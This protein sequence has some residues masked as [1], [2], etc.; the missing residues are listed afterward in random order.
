MKRM[1]PGMV[2]PILAVCAL[3]FALCSV[4][5]NAAEVQGPQSGRWTLAASPYI[6]TGNVVVPAGEQLAIDPGVV[7]KV[8]GDFSIKVEGGLQAV[9]TAGNRIVFTSI[10]DRDFFGM[11]VPETGQPARDDWPGIIFT[12]KSLSAKNRLEYVII[13]YSRNPISA[14]AANPE[15]VNMTID[16][17]A[18]NVMM[19]NGRIVAIKPGQT[20][21]YTETKNTAPA[22]DVTK[23]QANAAQQNM[24]ENLPPEAAATL[25]GQVF[26]SETAEALPAVNIQLIPQ[27]RPNQRLGT[28]TG[29]A[30]E[31]VIG[32]LPP[33]EYEIRVSYISYR[34]QRQ[35]E[36]LQAGEIKNLEFALEYTGILFNPITVT[37][38]RR[39]EA[40]L[41]AP[42]AI[43]VLETEEILAREALNP[44]EHL[45]GMPAVD[46]ASTGLNSAVTVARGFNNV[47]SGTLLSLVDNRITRAP[48]LRV[49]SYQFIPNVSEDYDRIE[50]VLGPGSALYGPN[51]A[52]G[53]MHILTKSPFES[54]GTTI[55][56]GGGERNIFE[57]SFRHAKVLND[58]IAYKISG[59]YYQGT[60]WFFEDEEEA[61]ARQQ[62]LAAGANPN[63]LKIGARNYDVERFAGDARLDFQ[64]NGDAT[65]T[66]NAGL[67]RSSNVELTGIGA[68][69]LIDWTYSYAQSRLAYKNLF[70][71][72]FVNQSDAGDTF[73]LRTGN[74]IVDRSQLFVG[75]LQHSFDFGPR[76]RFVYGLDVLLTRPHTGGTVNGANE[77]NDGINEF[78]FYVQSESDLL[79]KLTFIAAGRVD[80]HN[81]IQEPVFSPRVALIF[82]PTLTHAI[83]ATFNRA[84]STPTSNNLFLDIL[85]E[86]TANP[87]PAPLRSA[88]NL[89]TDIVNVRVRG[90][91]S[92]TGFSFRYGQDGRALMYS[93]FDLAAGYS[94]A[95]INTVWPK[96][97]TILTAANPQLNA[98]LP[99]LLSQ[100][101]P[102]IYLNPATGKPMGNPMN[103]EPI[104]ETV[105][106]T[107]EL[108]Y[109]GVLSEKLTVAADIYR[110]HIENFVSPLLVTTPTAYAVQAV[111]GPVLEEDIYKR[112]LAAGS[113]DP[114]A[115]ATAQGVV[116]GIFDPNSPLNLEAIPLGVATPEQVRSDVSII[117]TYRNF[118]NVWLTGADVRF[119]YVFNPGYTLNANYSYVN[120]D[121]FSNLDGIAGIALNAPKS[122]LNIGFRYQNAQ[123]SMI[124]Q[125]RLRH[126]AGFPVNS[127]TYIG[128]VD[129][130]TLLDFTFSYN[131]LEST[132]LTLTIQNILNN[133]HREM[134]GAPEIG[135]LAML[136]LR[137]SF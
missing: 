114:V 9:G 55:S 102:L 136:R 17:C 94:D 97:R 125:V 96:I 62:A 22:P 74:P 53:V 52:N 122:K 2:A 121:I 117:A 60:D 38:S 33:D 30:G 49:N 24:P 27:S 26:D 51:S 6:V 118:G 42:A 31:F 81:R 76:Q 35:K 115:R 1:Q 120:H 91:P 16:R 48:S 84:F 18:A 126:I 119:R 124:Y 101:V 15:L 36:I 19:V 104:R 77:K 127:G 99:D 105:T 4:P 85:Q 56:V 39:P 41:D 110:T 135:R 7:I 123:N 46:V 83:R 137:H 128:N 32:D 70:V 100:N 10:R 21:D 40:F 11:F 12:E 68:G 61:R 67:T 95:N 65:L 66:L 59:Q 28:A 112:L 37:A 109:K 134:V 103:V 111:V 130:Y 88:L 34:E 80:E 5:A 54:P 116:A 71:Q 69:Q 8:A 25:R 63:T 3:I 90:V 93:Q 29:P 131:F 13:R 108:G 78:G 47:F 14:E 73:L 58:R 50:L 64:I 43:S 57:A 107:F 44:A 20:V 82:K 129:P 92:E 23:Q 75:Q 79:P 87:L 133:E 113:S 132:G 106:N 98:L 89:N 72:G 86:R 45:K